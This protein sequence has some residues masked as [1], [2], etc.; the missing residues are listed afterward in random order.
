[1]QLYLEISGYDYRLEEAEFKM[2]LRKNGSRGRR[3]KKYMEE[4][5]VS[6]MLKCQVQHN[7]YKTTKSSY[8]NDVSCV[9]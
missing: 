8:S 6:L 9:L 4:T 2:A 1:M 7:L 3:R 5:L